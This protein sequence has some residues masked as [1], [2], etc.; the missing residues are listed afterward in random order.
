MY[1]LPIVCDGKVNF[2][3]VKFGND[4]LVFWLGIF[5]MPSKSGNK[6]CLYRDSTYVTEPLPELWNLRNLHEWKNPL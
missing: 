1:G 4:F 5:Y 6:K 2:I 3:T